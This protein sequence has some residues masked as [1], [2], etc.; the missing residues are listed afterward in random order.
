[1]QMLNK[2]VA[3]WLMLGTG[4]MAFTNLDTISTNGWVIAFAGWSYVFFN[5]FT[6]KSLTEN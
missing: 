4:F 1:M 3:G 5:E 6:R 2:I